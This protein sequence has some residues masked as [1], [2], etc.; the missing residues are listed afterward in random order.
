MASYKD[1]KTYWDYNV[2][3]LAKYD[4]Q[5]FINIIFETKMKELKALYYKN[6]DMS[7]DE[8]Y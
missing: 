5:A 4:M 7:E 2:D 8:I 3:H 1:P 6:T